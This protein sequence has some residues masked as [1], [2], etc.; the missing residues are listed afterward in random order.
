MT[1]G[2]IN[3]GVLCVYRSQNTV[4]TNNY[5][6]QGKLPKT[7]FVSRIGFF[8]F[9][10]MNLTALVDE[11]VTGLPT[12]YNIFNTLLCDPTTMLWQSDSRVHEISA[13]TGFD[14]GC[15]LSVLLL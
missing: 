10:T 9:G 3:R 7:V 12:L 2:R 14:L 6:D 11:A 13:P 4:I 5:Q 15:P 8:R 1:A